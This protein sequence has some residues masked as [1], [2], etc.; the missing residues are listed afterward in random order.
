[1]TFKPRVIKN[2]SDYDMAMDRLSE[3]I[4]LC[5][6]IDSPE[7]DELEHISI[8]IEHYEHKNFKIDKPSAIDAIK[9][10][11]DQDGLTQQDMEKYLGS[12]SK[13]SEVL[14]GKRNLSIAMITKLHYELGVPLD[15]L[16]QKPEDIDISDDDSQ[17][18]SEIKLSKSRTNTEKSDNK[19]EWYTS[20]KAAQDKIINFSRDHNSDIKETQ[21]AL[22]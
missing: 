3:L 13:V 21:W 1:M 17:M 12:R 19:S 16:I 18:Q 7:A 14:S 5:P 22:N 10:R 15:I 6:T 8:L 20:S 9:F 11:M 2:D 4:E